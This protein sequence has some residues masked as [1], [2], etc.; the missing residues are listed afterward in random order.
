MT[1]NI[2]LGARRSDSALHSGRTNLV[3]DRVGRPAR[4]L[5]ATMLVTYLLSVFVRGNSTREPQRCVVKSQDAD[6]R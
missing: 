5:C 6:I 3:T 4:A 2:T 1:Y